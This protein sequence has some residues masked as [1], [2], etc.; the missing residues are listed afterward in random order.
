M[1]KVMIPITILLPLVGGI[2]L[3]LQKNLKDRRKRNGYVLLV[4]ILTFVSVLYT[5]YQGNTELLLWNLTK[6]IPI[7]FHLDQLGALFAVL[8]SFMWL[9][10]AIYSFEYM[11]HEKNEG[12]YDTAFLLALS[13]I[14]GICFAGNLITMYIFY[15]FMTLAGLPMVLHS[16]SKE[17]IKAGKKYLFYSIGGAFLG[18]S[19][20]VF[21]Y[22]YGTSLAFTP[23]GVLNLTKVSGHETSLL[24]VTLLVIIGFGSKAGMFPLHGWLPTAHPVAPAPASAFLSSI[25][26]KMGVFVIIRYLYYLIGADFLRGTWVQYCAISFTLLTILM[27]SMMAYKEPALKKRLAYSTVSQVSYILF[28][29]FL[30]NPIGLM[31]GLMHIIFHS[32]VK[33]VLFFAAGAIIFKTGK[34]NVCELTGI[35]K[36]MP[37]TMWCFTLASLT[38]VGIPPTSA[39]LSKWYLATGSLETA[40]PILSWLGPIILIVSALLTAGYLITISMK[41]FFPGDDFHYETLENMEPLWYMVV[42]MV[43]LTA[44]AVLLGMFPTMLTNFLQTIISAII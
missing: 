18:F 31:G 34:K 29:I 24:I 3:P 41:G 25:M 8:V 19:G 17:A 4:I 6:D 39:F 11:K 15:E 42:P 30:M 23:G 2:F 43:I 14:L 32:M 35:G 44:G 38:L 26:T 9:M 40:I 1:E 36:R 28:G 37:V 20:F 12:R 13:A 10:S 27:G 22:S 16:L 5:V 7:Y 33:S 21:I